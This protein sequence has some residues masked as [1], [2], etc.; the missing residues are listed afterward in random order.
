[1]NPVTQ[2]RLDREL[3]RLTVSAI[4]DGLQIWSQDG[5]VPHGL[6]QCVACGEPYVVLA[7]KD[8]A[9]TLIAYSGHKCGEEQ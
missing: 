5:V 8:E 3:D 2:A 4:A 7:V 1:M 6:R 9:G